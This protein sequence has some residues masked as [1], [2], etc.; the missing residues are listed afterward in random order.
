MPAVFSRGKTSVAAGGVRMVRGDGEDVA[1][2]VRLAGYGPW[3]AVFDAAGPVPAVVRDA[4][5][6]LVSAAGLYVFV[7]PSPRLPASG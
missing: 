3:A 7:S 5:R 6:V 2:L 1:D 4:A